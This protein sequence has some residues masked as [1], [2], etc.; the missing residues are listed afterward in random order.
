MAFDRKQEVPDEDSSKSSDSR[1]VSEL[2]ESFSERAFRSALLTGLLLLVLLAVVHAIVFCSKENCFRALTTYS[3]SDYLAYSFTP[4]D[5]FWIAAFYGM[6]MFTATFLTVYLNSAIPGVEPPLPWDRNM[7]PIHHSVRRAKRA[8]A[9][10]KRFRSYKD[11]DVVYVDAAEYGKNT[12]TVAVV[13][14]KQLLKISASI[15][16]GNPETAE[17]AAIA[18]AC[19]GT[20][21]RYIISDSKVAIL[22]FSRGRV[23]PLT[24]TILSRHVIDRKI[25]LVWTPA[26]ASLPGNETAHEFTRGFSFRADPSEV[27]FT[28]RDRMV[29]YREIT[30]HYRLQRARLPPADRSLS[31]YQAINWRRLQTYTF[32]NPALWSLMYPGQFSEKCANCE[33]RA[34]L[35]HIVWECPHAPREGRGINTKDQWETLL[36]SSDPATQLQLVRLAEAAAESQDHS[37]V[38]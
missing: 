35:D 24:N 3:L 26:H 12:M 28:D 20:K 36:L 16:S 10:E 29:T 18:L 8:E 27:V 7:H 15:L 5:E 34:T 31:R 4:S 14:N 2:T 9:L 19:V 32:P 30:Q 11:E 22:N 6:G 33:L 38:V 23:S 37:A 25:T 17:E 13:N 21:A 1:Y